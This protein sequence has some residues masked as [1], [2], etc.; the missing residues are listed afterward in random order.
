MKIKQYSLEG[1]LV[2][3]Y[4][5]IKDVK[6]SNR[7]S[8]LRCCEGKYKTAGGYVWR[9]EHENFSLK[10]TR[11][12]RNEVLCKICNSSESVRSMAMHLK[13]A[14]N[15]KTEEYIIKYGEFRPK[16]IKENKLKEQSLFKCN[17][18]GEK[19]KSN[20]HLM[21]HITKKHSNISKSEY[22]I[23]YV[24]DNKIPACKCG[25]GEP[26]SILENG[27]NCDLGKE[28]Y[29]RDYIKG[30]WDW[31]VFSNIGKQS[32]EELELLEFIKNIYKGE[33]KTNVRLF[34]KNEIDIY[35]PEL[36]IGIE[37]NGLYWHSEKANRFKDYHFNKYKQAIDNNIRLIQIF[38]DEWLNKK[39]IVKNKLRSVLNIT[40]TK[41]YAR[42]CSIKEILFKEKNQFLD[43]YHIQGSDRSSIK[44]GLFLKE[45]LVA[46]M[47]FSHPRIALGGNKNDKKIY[48]LSRYA[49]KYNVIGG[50][51]KLLNFFIK[52]FNPTKIYSYSDNRWTDPNNNMYL[53]IGFKKEKE[54]SPNYF[55]T[56]DYLKRYHRFNFNKKILKKMGCDVNKTEFEIM[57]EL[58]Y[59]KIW[60]CGTTKF[61]KNFS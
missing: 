7:D 55:Y 5:D 49:T 56:K 40:E 36:N 29:H 23:K 6:I 24:L 53:K 12:K 41:I 4:N 3:L 61:V 50:A 35:L 13:W 11:D 19:V 38:S 14:H 59:T 57:E 22:I 54:S 42:K 25:C 26:V 20:Q 39:N 45:E 27:K 16:N 31:E 33:I 1:H 52:N 15:I 37:Y 47:T 28:T 18:C 2:K 17:I 34:P 58:G 10:S 46:V 60:D 44:L 9:F 43:N 30:H 48:E 8:I 21:Y 51:S 32:K